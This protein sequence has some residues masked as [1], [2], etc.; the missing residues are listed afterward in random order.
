LENMDSAGWT[1]LKTDIIPGGAAAVAFTDFMEA[2]AA[3]V[4][5]WFDGVIDAIDSAVINPLSTWYGNLQTQFNVD[6]RNTWDPL[7]IDMDGD[8]VNADIL[9]GQQVYFD[10]NNNGLAEAINWVNS[11][12]GFLVRD[13]NANGTIDNGGEL[14]GDQTTNGFAALKT[15]DSNADGK[16]TAA[17]AAFSS[18]KIWQDLNKNGISETGE[19]QTLTAAGITSIDVANYSVAQNALKGMTHTGTAQTASGT[20]IEVANIAFITDQRNTAYTKDYDLDLRAIFLPT[21][22]GYG[23]LTDFHTALSLDNGAAT[24]TLMSQALHLVSYGMNDA[25]ANWSTIR[26]E[27]KTMLFNWADVEGINPTSRGVYVNAQELTFL[28]NYLGTDFINGNFDS[29]GFQTNPGAQQALSIHDVFEQISDRLMGSFFEQTALSGLFTHTGQYSIVNDS[30]TLADFHL[31][32][33]TLDALSLYAVGLADTTARQTFWIGVTDFINGVRTTANAPILNAADETL[34]NAAIT[35]SDAA[36]VWY[37]ESHN[38][39]G[40]VTSVEYRYD[41]P[42]GEVIHGTSG[43]DTLTGTAAE[44]TI[45]GLGGADTIHGSNLADRIFGHSADGVGDDGAADTLYGDDGNDYLDGGAGN[46]TLYGGLGNDFLLGGDGNDTLDSAGAGAEQ[47]YMSGGSGN[48]TFRTSFGTNESYVEGGTGSDTVVLTL[49]I[50][51]V[52]TGITF[53]R[54]GDTTLRII[55]SNPSGTVFANIYL[56]DQFSNSSADIGVEFI[57]QTNNVTTDLKAYLLTYMTQIKT[58]GSDSNDVIHGIRMV[59]NPNDLIY[60]FA[61]DD[62]IY[63]DDGNDRLE[64]GDGNDTLYGGIGNDDLRGENGNDTIYGEDGNDTLNGGTGDNYIDGGAGNDSIQ[65]SGTAVIY[66]RDGDDII[67]ADNTTRSEIDGGVGNDTIYGGTGND[68]IMGGDGTDSLY[69]LNGDDTFI[70]DAGNDTIDGGN[71]SDTLSYQNATSGI[72][73]NLALGYADAAGMGHDTFINIENL[74]GSAFADTLTGTSGQNTLWGGDGNDTLYGGANSDNLYGENGDDTLD[75]GRGSTD[76]VNGGTGNDTVL[77]ASYGFAVTVS[78]AATGA[79]TV[80]ASNIDTLTLTDV[81]NLVGTSF[82]DTLT[83]N[84]V[85]NTLNGMDGNDTLSGGLG[86][87]ILIGGIGSDTLNGGDGNDKA[88]Y[89]GSSAAVTINLLTNTRVGR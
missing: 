70:G 25:F 56:V 79:Q 23:K 41:N 47:N 80:S 78:L 17:D 55:A 86:D 7:V 54:F 71:N 63:G 15:L 37:K 48:D 68:V 81:E 45:E 26:S 21:L 20:N 42:A 38:P 8:G 32:T 82:G 12:D 75:A 35:A 31:S 28:E 39:L 44:D 46:D 10:L 85:A 36:L 2:N 69:G 58:Y 65:S 83:G 18:L 67:N 53:A 9:T 1:Q 40:G 57:K 64:G 76:K 14:F 77:L 13:L 66:G 84:D 4:S 6:I 89:T 60:G 19:L 11:N 43:T 24:T 59:G 72:N 62:T 3:A 74:R 73:V 29:S 30:V 33:S 87:D 49:P 34:L 61:G 5:S 50:A 51:D 88:K 22:R 16:I 27:F 52:A